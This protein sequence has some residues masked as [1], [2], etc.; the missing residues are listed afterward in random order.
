VSGYHLLPDTVFASMC[1]ADPSVA[2]SLLAGQASKRL[3]QLRAIL[4]A[5]DRHVPDSGRAAGVDASF[6]A[7]VRIQRHAP[8][9]VADLLVSPQV[10]AWAASCLRHVSGDAR[11]S[12]PIP[13][14]A[15]LA[16]LGAIAATAA[17]RA[18][19][20]VDV[21]VPALDGVVSFPTH[22]IATVDRSAP[23]ALLGCRTGGSPEV[24]LDGAPP[25]TWR[26]M[27]RLHTKHGDTE[28]TV[29]LDDVDPYWRTL[30]HPLSPRLTDSAVARWQH[31]LSDAGVVLAVRHGEWLD[32]VAG[33]TRC[34]VP[35]EPSGA[36]GMS[37][38][39]ADAPGAVALTEPPN[40]ARM[41]ATLIHETQHSRLNLLHD[42]LPLFRSTGGELYY[43]PW[44]DDPRPPGGVM[45]GVYAFL[46]V[47]AFWATERI[48]GSPS[49]RLEYA[50][51]LRQLRLGHQVLAGMPEL[52]AAGVGFVDELGRAIERLPSVAAADADIDRIAADLVTEHLAGWR[53]A[54]VRPGDA[55]ISAV[56]AAW[57]RGAP[58]LL[59]PDV[60]MRANGPAAPRGDRPLTRLAMR[61]VDDVPEGRALAVA[62]PMRHLRELP[63]TTVADLDLLAGA[64]GEASAAY[65]RR[66]VDGPAAD[67]D[68]ARLVVAA[69][70]RGP[71]GAPLI[72][73]PE[74]VRA[75]WR[76]AVSGGGDGDH[77]LRDLAEAAQTPAG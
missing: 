68:W 67:D 58:P 37:A 20:E 50:R 3:V 31:L 34:L 17:L 21:R 27:P 66:I 5:V 75:A 1:A 49:V 51:H 74:L 71:A 55:E 70:R 15:E 32:T 10:G 45:H 6:G 29:L 72:T 56:A 26:A 48:D 64:Y 44:R 25:S 8:G 76:R 16:R 62:D 28:L 52:S 9:V 69:R 11:D 18:G 73:R 36:G 41:S 40:G 38:S 77:L 2:D 61:W 14:H 42:L 46:G 63:G 33:V 12:A 59:L 13:L 24:L 23:V 60:P 43:S 65:R 22:A 35:I 39:S 57:L 47:A 4:D 19:L 53:L 54:H 7:L 30:R